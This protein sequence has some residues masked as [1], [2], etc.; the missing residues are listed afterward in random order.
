MDMTEVTAEAYAACVGKGKCSDE[1]VTSCN[2]M[3]ATWGN[4]TTTQ[5]PMTCVSWVQASTYCK[6]AGK[7]LPTEEEWEWAARGGDEAR[8]YPWGDM[9]PASQLCWA[10]T[11]DLGSCRVGS[12]PLGNARWGMQD[13]GGNVW[14]WTSSAAA[15]DDWRVVRGGGWDADP[16]VYRSS[17]SLSYPAS[18]RL[19][20]LGFRC[21]RTL[22]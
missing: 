16:S 15:N 4:P 2:P 1:K 6:V 13:L 7:R 21:A 20:D 17:A 14:E 9:P 11:T 18:M 22:P 10:K 5:H 8:E 12:Y 19:D 3:F